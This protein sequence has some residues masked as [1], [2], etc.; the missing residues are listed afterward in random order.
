MDRLVLELSRQDDQL[1]GWA[2]F[3]ESSGWAHTKLPFDAEFGLPAVLKLLNREAYNADD[4]LDA[5][6]AFLRQAELVIPSGDDGLVASTAL[7]RQVGQRLMASLLPPNQ[8]AGYVFKSAYEA[9]NATL[10]VEIQFDANDG[11]VGALPWELLHFDEDFLFRGSRGT[12]SRRLNYPR[13]IASWQPVEVDRL[14]VLLIAPRPRDVSDLGEAEIQAIT[15]INELEVDFLPRP[16]VEE[17]FNY[18]QTHRRARAPHVI[19]FDGHGV[20]GRRCAACRMVSPRRAPVCRNPACGRDMLEDTAQGYLAWEGPS[21]NVDFVSAEDFADKIGKVMGDEGCALR[22]VVVSACRSAQLASGGSAFSGIAQRLNKANVPAVVAM[23]LDILADQAT[24]FAQALYRGLANG[25]SVV[26]A[27]AW[28]RTGLRQDQQWYCPVLYLRAVDD[29]EARFFTFR[30]GATRSPERA[31]AHA[32]GAPPDGSTQRSETVVVSN[33]LVPQ[34]DD[35]TAASDEQ[36]IAALERGVEPLLGVP[37]VAHALVPYATDFGACIQQLEAFTDYKLLHDRLHELR[38]FC[39]RPLRFQLR[40]MTDRDVLTVMQR[41]SDAARKHVMD[42]QAVAQRRPHDDNLGWVAKLV[43]CEAELRS[44]VSSGRPTIV[45]RALDRLATVLNVYPTQLNVLMMQSAEG[46]RLDKVSEAL[47]VAAPLVVP[48]D[49][50]ARALVA[51]AAV[52]AQHLKATLDRALAEHRD[53]QELEPDLADA[54]ALLTDEDDVEGFMATW[55]QISAALRELCKGP[56]DDQELL[57]ASLER[58]QALVDVRQ[59]IGDKLDAPLREAFS[60]CESNATVR[61]FNVDSNLRTLLIRL[62]PLSGRLDALVIG[63]RQA[64]GAS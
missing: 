20:F 12:L 22:M 10:P 56:T 47:R 62:G 53:W 48:S 4:Y 8:Q 17:F 34:T 64:G 46:L 45:R 63:I 28:A 58:V 59:S 44:G 24:T 15:S 42:I 1:H 5:E 43:G 61:F 7:R 51:R 21:Q 19:H 3:G 36:L 55:P 60:Q 25:D 52:A 26:D 32:V 33:V 57:Q 9:L 39:F 35:L 54:D 6:D 13:H 40:D 29:T 37:S 38:V 41:D 30:T 27:L 16:T 31:P 49:S 50:P 14:R 23:Q 11:T 2:R 18:L